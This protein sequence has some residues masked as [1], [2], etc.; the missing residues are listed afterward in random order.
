[1]AL[2]GSRRDMRWLSCRVKTWF[3]LYLA[4][5]LRKSAVT[6]PAMGI[7]LSGRFLRLQRVTELEECRVVLS[8]S[9]WDIRRLS[10]H[11]ETSFSLYL[12]WLLRKSVAIR[13]RRWKCQFRSGCSESEAA[14][15]RA[16]SISVDL[17]SMGHTVAEL[18]SKNV[19][20]PAFSVAVR[21]K[22]CGTSGSE[23][24]CF[25]SV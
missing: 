10:S 18:S 4:W 16:A 20:F 17:E 22:Y 21:L 9:R 11:V 15:V 23:Q 3:S 5:R 24:Y 8:G 1:M 12:A 2:T 7:K 19:V 13:F 6:L 25:R 14:G